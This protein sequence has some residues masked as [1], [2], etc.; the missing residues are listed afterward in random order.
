[1]VAIALGIV[2]GLAGLAALALGM[3]AL[4]FTTMANAP[5]G[6]AL[7]PFAIGLA[8]IGIGSLLIFGA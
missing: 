1:M 2:L 5:R 4:P 8:C 6:E 7:T 3:F